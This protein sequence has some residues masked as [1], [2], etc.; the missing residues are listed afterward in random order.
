MWASTRS[1]RVERARF[2]ALLLGLAFAVAAHASVTDRP[3]P[4]PAGVRELAPNLEARGGGQLTFLGI[5]IYD[6][7]YWSA[8]RGWPADVP[9]ALDLVYHRDLDGEKIAQRSTEEIAKL[10]Y[11][12]PEQR[13]RWGALMTRIFP[14]VRKGD[15]LTGVHTD[16][17]AVR[18]F[19]NGRPIGTIDEPGFARAFFGI[20]LDPKSSRADF[21][22]KL[23][24]RP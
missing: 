20:W 1:K 15:R 18:Y 7:W 14:D 4:L 10:G 12:T 6:G 16:T 21:R 22:Q 11:G 24:G 23:L 17:G 2:A 3:P 13:A 8:A 9:Y 19:Y 5:A